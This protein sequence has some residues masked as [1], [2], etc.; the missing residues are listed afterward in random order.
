LGL[1]VRPGREGLVK[2]GIAAGLSALGGSL[3]CCQFTSQPLFHRGSR[4]V[5]AGGG[6]IVGLQ[7]RPGPGRI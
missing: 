2:I 6:T 3:P 7:G 4:R 1:S 5:S